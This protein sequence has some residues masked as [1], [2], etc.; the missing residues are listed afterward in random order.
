MAVTGKVTM[1]VNAPLEEAYQKF[2]DFSRWGEWMPEIFR[3]VSGPQRVLTG[4]DAIKVKLKAVGP[5]MTMPIKVFR[6]SPNREITWGG[7]AKGLLHAEHCFFFEDAGEGRTR[8]RSEETF[9]G[10]LTLPAPGFLKKQI[11]TIGAAQLE[12]F[13]AW[14]SK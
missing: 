10:A 8:I 6:S 12:G 1:I 14:V 9:S 5:A 13:S 11:E 7:G 3:P 2:C 4:G